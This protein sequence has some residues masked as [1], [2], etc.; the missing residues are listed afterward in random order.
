LGVP[1]QAG[2]VGFFK[3]SFHNE[4]AEHPGTGVKA[5]T[6]HK[7]S[8]TRPKEKFV[9]LGFGAMLTDGKQN[10]FVRQRV[11]WKFLV[12]CPSNPLFSSGLKPRLAP[13]SGNT[14]T[15]FAPVFVRLAAERYALPGVF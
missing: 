11:A 15:Q 13:H 14:I 9:A 2:R 12:P 4:L 7:S 1:W 8:I 6:S 5:D 10:L 3:V